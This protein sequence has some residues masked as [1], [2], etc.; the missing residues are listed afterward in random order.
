MCC[1]FPALSVNKLAGPSGVTVQLQGADGHSCAGSA[2]FS[3]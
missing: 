1:V 2:D 3:H